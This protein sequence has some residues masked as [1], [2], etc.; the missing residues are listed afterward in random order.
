VPQPLQNFAPA[1]SSV[2]Q[3]V[4]KCF[5][6]AACTTGLPQPAQ[7]FA[8][9]ASLVEQPGQFAASPCWAFGSKSAT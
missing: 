3:P 9:G 7:N 5:A 8:P 6:A 4:Q 2:P 1:A